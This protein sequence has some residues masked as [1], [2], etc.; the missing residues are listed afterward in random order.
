M[1]AIRSYYGPIPFS[2]YRPIERIAPGVILRKDVALRITSY[3][4]CYTKLLRTDPI[5]SPTD[6]PGARLK[7]S[8]RGGR[9]MKLI[10]A[11]FENRNNFV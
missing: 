3:N 7:E 4:V 6:A 5:A 1:Y 10:R 9:V 8:L 11:E 2:G